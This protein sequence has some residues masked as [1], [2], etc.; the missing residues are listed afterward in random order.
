MLRISPD[1]NRARLSLKGAAVALLP[2]L[3]VITFISCGGVASAQTAPDTV[4]AA[5]LGP[6]AVKV[7]FTACLSSDEGNCNIGFSIYR[8]PQP[9]FN[10]PPIAP[11]YLGEG[12]YV[13]STEAIWIDTTVK[14]GQSYTYRVCTGDKAN[15]TASNCT[16]TTPVTVPNPPPPPPPPPQAGVQ[17]T[18]N[19]TVVQQG[20]STRLTWTSEN[21]TNVTMTWQPGPGALYNLPSSSYTNFNPT[22]T[23][24]YTVYVSG[25]Y[26]TAHASVT[27]GVEPP[28][29]HTSWAPP[30]QVYW[31]PGMSDF[32]LKWTN[33]NTPK[34]QTCPAP[35]NQVLIYRM[36]GTV[37][38][39][40]QVAVLNQTTN[41]GTLPTRY[42]D[43]GPLLPGTNYWYTVC[44]GGPPQDWGDPN[45][46]SAVAGYTLDASPVLTATRVNA[47]TVQLQIAV[48]QYAV[49]SITVRRDGSDDPSR[50]GVK[51]GNGLMGCRTVGPNGLPIS[52]NWV[53]VYNWTQVIGST[54]NWTWASKTA[55]Y[56]ID[57]PDDTTVKSGIEYYY[58]VEVSWASGQDEDSEVVT[59]PVFNPMIMAQHASVGGLQPLKLS[60]G[61]PAPSQ[62]GMAARP[63][64]APMVRPASP[65]ISSASPMMMNP[66]GP[67]SAPPAASQSGMAARPAVAPRVRPASPTITSASPMMSSAGPTSA[68]P[69]ASQ[70]TMPARAAVAPIVSTTSPMMPSPGPTAGPCPPPSGTAASPTMAPMVRSASLAMP[71]AGP[72]WRPA[73]QSATAARLSTAPINAPTSRMAPSVRSAAPPPG[74]ANVEAAMKQVEQKPG[75]AQALYALGKAYCASGVRDTGV[76]YMYMALLLAENADNASLAAQIKSSLAGLG[77]SAK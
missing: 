66:A 69:A 72:V 14:K 41:N 48:D 65:M 8:S 32:S 3:L 31:L 62:S 25:Q 67:T 33:P 28:A 71:P 49:A 53:T 76:S 74:A 16:T 34:G 56:L 7:T 70:S 15:S 58:Q 38:S 24:T 43:N 36:G 19:P 68:P 20:Q 46:C 37:G 40:E 4:T 61:A 52:A 51:L 30:Q 39:Y 50:Q 13:G 11:A 60:S 26:G 5:A 2:L 29:C 6:S 21:A 18:A 45:N 44:E 63:A 1:T 73:L 35:S 57:I 17:L 54:P 59:V 47:T 75:D 10:Q 55:P 64:V 23:T 9:G 12:T 27:V 22:Q 42:T 77:V